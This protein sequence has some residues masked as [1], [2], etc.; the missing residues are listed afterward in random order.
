MGAKEI[1]WILIG[2]L[3]LFVGLFT[4]LGVVKTILAIIVVILIGIIASVIIYRHNRYQL[5]LTGDE[6]GY[7]KSPVESDFDQIYMLDKLVFKPEDLIQKEV[8][9]QWFQANNMTF[10]VFVVANEVIGYYSMLPLRQSTLRKFLNGTI[11]EI[12]FT[13]SDILGQQEAKNSRSIYFFSIVIDKRFSHRGFQ[14]LQKA[15]DELRSRSTYPY[16][17]SIY[18][19]ASTSDGIRILRKSGFFKSADASA[20]KDKHDLYQYSFAK[21]QEKPLII[22]NHQRATRSR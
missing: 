14:L 4:E 8:F 13:K 3:A 12:D 2:A 9:I 19:T 22:K 10:T 15:V 21:N 16:L 1:I 18:A 5:I 7:F 17:E 11:S 20:R 6:I